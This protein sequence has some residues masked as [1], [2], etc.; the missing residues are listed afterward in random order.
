[1]LAAPHCPSQLPLPPCPVGL[2]SPFG[3]VSL[4]FLFVY[5]QV[6]MTC[7]RIQDIVF[8]EPQN[9]LGPLGRQPALPCSSER[10]MCPQGQNRAS[11]Q[12]GQG[13]P[14]TGV[15]PGVERPTLG[16]PSSYWGRQGT[17]AIPDSNSPFLSHCR[18]DRLRVTKTTLA[19]DSPLPENSSYLG[20]QE[21]PG[22]SGQPKARTSSTLWAFVP[23]VSLHPIL[24]GKALKNITLALGN[25]LPSSHPSH[26]SP[27]PPLHFCPSS[28]LLSKYRKLIHGAW[29][30]QAPRTYIWVVGAFPG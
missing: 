5:S 18:W 25:G 26:F 20:S 1:M 11:K 10:N 24:P 30:F 9:Q 8:A 7:F 13:S 23:V 6:T 29:G 12:E 17:S 3:L 21:S 28:P 14:A 22:P 27:S 19:L 15:E 4:C 2:F 16:A